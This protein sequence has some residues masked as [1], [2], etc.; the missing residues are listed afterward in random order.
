MLNNVN[1][2][3]SICFVTTEHFNVQWHL[4]NLIHGLKSDYNVVVIGNCVSVNSMKFDNVI[5][6]KGLLQARGLRKIT[7][8]EAFKKEAAR[9]AKDF[10]FKHQHAV[11]GGG[12]YR[13]R[14]GLFH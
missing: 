5:L 8:I 1:N 12:C 2:K 14:H 4:F 11:N 10:G 9:I 7:R 13:V 3:I 6:H